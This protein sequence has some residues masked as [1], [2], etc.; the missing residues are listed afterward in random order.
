MDE[1]FRD[2]INQPKNVKRSGGKTNTFKE[3]GV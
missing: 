2:N 1:I 3:N